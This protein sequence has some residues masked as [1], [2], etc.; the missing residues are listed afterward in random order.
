LDG[1]VLFVGYTS[2]Y[3][4]VIQIQHNNDYISVYK[5]NTESLT[6]QGNKVK[7]GEVIGMIGKSRATEG[8]PHLYFE[9]WHKGVALNPEQ[10]IVF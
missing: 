3:G 7:A 2:D 4:Y 10:Y 1:T 9:L 5:Y 6:K 8:L